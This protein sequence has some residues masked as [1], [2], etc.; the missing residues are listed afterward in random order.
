MTEHRKAEPSNELQGLIDSTLS[1]IT[2]CNAI[3]T[4]RWLLVDTRAQRL[5]LVRE[6]A[7]TRQWPVSTSDVGLD[8]RENSGGTPPGV[9]RVAQKIGTGAAEG[10]VFESR[11]PTGEIWSL[12]DDDQA[13]SR[14]KDLILTRILLLDGLEEG[15]NRGKGVDSRARYIYV[16][17]TNQEDQL[18][19]PVSHGCVRMG[20]R[21]LMDL[22][23]IVEE[24]D[25][26]VI[27]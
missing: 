14:K 13:E 21:H 17:G 3:P 4:A 6:G 22:F 20:N 15:L 24:G 5:V 2:N 1:L 26:L 9:H 7:P 10:T 8:N 11:Q 27:V 23:D 12:P 18:G 19:Q 16:H 25:L